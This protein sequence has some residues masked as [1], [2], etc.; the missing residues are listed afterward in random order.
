MQQG[1]ASSA[2]AELILKLYELRTETVMRQARAWIAGEFWQREKQI[3][4]LFGHAQRRVHLFV[5][6][7][8]RQRTSRLADRE[9]HQSPGMP[10]QCGA[11]RPHDLRAF[12][13]REVAPTTIVERLPGGTNRHLDLVD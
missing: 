11:V 4:D 2:D 12:F 7:G 13:V 8:R 10:A 9:F 5:H 3:D 1:M 6:H